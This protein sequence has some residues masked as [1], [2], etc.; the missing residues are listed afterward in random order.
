MWEFG[1]LD[2]KDLSMKLDLKTGTLTPIIQKLEKQGYLKRLGNPNDKRKVNVVLT[3]EGKELGSKARN[4]PGALASRL[5]LD[6][7]LYKKY[8]DVLDEIGVKLNEAEAR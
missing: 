8:F 6:Y 3:E 4:V 2:F 7:D 5:S 1:E